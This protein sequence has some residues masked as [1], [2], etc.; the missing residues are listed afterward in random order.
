ML[1]TSI[2]DALD[3]VTQVSK[4]SRG[5]QGPLVKRLKVTVQVIRIMSDELQRRIVAKERE[6]ILQ[7]PGRASRSPQS[8]DCGNGGGESAQAA[9]GGPEA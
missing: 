2:V 6:V 8:G 7:S 4:K 9:L 1:G 3:A 5:L